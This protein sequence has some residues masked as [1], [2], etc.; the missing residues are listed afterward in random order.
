VGE[1][2]TPGNKRP[3]EKVR[4]RLN[5]KLGG[6]QTYFG[7]G[8]TANAYRTLDEYV[9][10]PVRQ[11]LRKRQKVSS[12]SKSLFS[13]KPVREPAVKP[14]GKPD[15]GNPHVRFDERCFSRSTCG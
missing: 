5:Q 3:W 2:L 7:R 9:E 10:Q 11:F 14:V 6:W 4:E 12:H 15:A 8:S 13:T 1:H